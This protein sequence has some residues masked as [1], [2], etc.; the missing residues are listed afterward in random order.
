MFS[1]FVVEEF[2]GRFFEI[3]R[4]HVLGVLPRA[5]TADKPNLQYLSYQNDDFSR[6]A[7]A[8]APRGRHLFFTD[9]TASPRPRAE[10]A[11]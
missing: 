5:Q 9:T 3:C 11:A 2:T 8:A 7:P 1:A 4:L 10:I 6:Y